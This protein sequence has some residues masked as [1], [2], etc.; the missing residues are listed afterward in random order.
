MLLIPTKTWSRFARVLRLPGTQALSG[1]QREIVPTQDLTNFLQADRVNHVLYQF[2]VTPAASENNDL[3][4]NDLSD[5]AAVAVN[6]ILASTDAELPQPDQD[7][8]ITAIGLQISAGGGDYTSGECNRF[9]PLPVASLL[10]MAEWGSITTGHNAPSL[11]APALLPQQLI[12]NET[13]VRLTAIV[14]GATAVHTYLIQMIAAEPG[15]LPA[16]PGA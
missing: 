2:T 1:I 5:W 15:I 6:G 3:V 9:A 11:V 10:P 16:F 7:R 4:W 13:S 8:I 12:V 14:S